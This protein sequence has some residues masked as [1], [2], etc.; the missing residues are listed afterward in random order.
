MI[1]RKNPL[2]Y[3]PNLIDWLSLF[4]QVFTTTRFPSCKM[5]YV[6][7]GSDFIGKSYNFIEKQEN[8]L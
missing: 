2:D 6:K 4:I 8:I 5:G 1:Q 7:A 3:V